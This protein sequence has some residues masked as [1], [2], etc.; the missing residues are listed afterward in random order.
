M[1]RRIPP[2][3]PLKMFESAA[4]H[5]NLTRAASELHVTQSAVSRQIS[6]LEEY[7]GV[8]LFNRKNRGVSL[9]AEGRAYATDIMSAFA[10][11]D[12]STKNLRASRTTAGLTVKTYMTFAVK[13][14]IPR[15]PEFEARHPEVDL[16][17][18]V[19][20][21]EVD[22]EQDDVDVAIQFGDGDW[23]KT[24]QDLLF[25][26]VVEPVCSPKFYETYLAHDL[27]MAFSQRLLISHYRRNDWSE[28]LEFAGLSHV[29]E[30]TERKTYSS[31]VLT[32]RAAMDG[33][34]MAIGQPAMLEPEF[35]AGQLMRPFNKPMKRELGYYLLAPPEENANVQKFRDWIL[36][37]SA[38]QRVGS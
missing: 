18:N 21:P 11:I 8:Q 2:L 16:Q 19:A 24:R 33:M 14:L 1:S 20:V 5:E 29:A 32:Y 6:I 26:D 23:A 37:M 9:T 17:L 28:W 25:E 3:N 36:E 27:N 4:R 15:L 34:G 12:S 35:E 10:L 13:W 30:H 7:L 38:P 22:F 31:S